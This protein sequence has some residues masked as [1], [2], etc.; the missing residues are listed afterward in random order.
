MHNFFTAVPPSLT[1]L[2]LLAR[3]DVLREYAWSAG[4][5]RH[6]V[7]RTM[8]IRASKIVQMTSTG[9]WMIPEMA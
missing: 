5:L 6:F 7:A 3:L 2:H 4:R 9:G 1:A 8:H